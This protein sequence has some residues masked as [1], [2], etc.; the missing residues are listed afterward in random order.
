MDHKLIE[1][2]NSLDMIEDI[3]NYAY[4]G[5]V[6]VDPQGRIVKMNYEKLLGIK[7]EDAI[8]KPVE[9][10]LENSRMHIVAKTGIKEL[11]DVQRMQGHDMITNRIPIIKNNKVIG[12]VGTVLF[13]DISEIKELAHQLLDL[14]SKIN[15]YKGEIERIQ[16]TKYSFHSIITRNPKMEYLKRIGER[17]ADTNSTVL[18]TGESGT[19][20]ELFAHAIH[21]ASYRK[22]EAFIALNCAAIPKDL[23]ESELFGYDGGAFTGAKKEGKIGKF[24][25]AAG[26]TLFLDEIGN[27]PMDMQV[28]LLRVL[29]A[30]EFERVG[31][32]E[33]IILDARIIAATNENIEEQIDEGKFREDLY[34]RLNVIPI[35]IPPLRERTEDI[36]ILAKDLLEKLLIDMKI[37]EKTL[38]KESIRILETYDWPG[39]VRELRNILESGI[40]LSSGN[41]ILPEHLPDRFLNKA[42]FTLED[43]KIDLLSELMAKTEKEAIEKALIITRGNK[44]LA[45]KELGIHRTALYK[46][47]DKYG[48]KQ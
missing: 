17:A 19:G 33:K 46:K 42:E 9:D 30:K 41:Q 7:E 34:Y 32:N 40:N 36:E 24:E 2:R 15:K 26:G 10:I 11:R 4:E 13:K 16:G 29:E 44:S 43:E 48:I 28:K 14:Q 35:E 8:G 37:S 1:L 22:E 31:G 12:A 3:L 27:M 6:L 38:S 23:L 45:A 5:Y 25:L 21:R 20:K 39:N 47:L 18:I